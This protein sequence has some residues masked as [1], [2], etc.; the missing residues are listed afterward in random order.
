M[1][2]PDLHGSSPLWEDEDAPAAAKLWKIANSIAKSLP[3][4]CQIVAGE[5]SGYSS[6]YFG[7]VN[8][9]RAW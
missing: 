8:V 1:N 3:C 7:P 4:A 6:Y 5:F 2:E 9:R